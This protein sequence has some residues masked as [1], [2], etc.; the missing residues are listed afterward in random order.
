MELEKYLQNSKTA[1][2][3]EQYKK[4]EQ[5]E[6]DT[7]KM[8]EADPSLASLAK[9][10]L[11]DLKT[12]KD[13][14]LAQ[15]EVITSEESSQYA[16][17]NAFPNEIILE[18]RAGAGGEEASL[19]AAELSHMYTRYAENQGWSVSKIEDLSFEIR[20]RDVYK[21]LRYE[22]GVHRVQ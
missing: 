8:I 3:A 2:L 11:L 6:E 17:E 1:Y 15:M 13:A 19:F 5:D 22:T 16:K 14:L 9:T 21:R 18:V 7:R 4:L 20:G 10:E 12:Q